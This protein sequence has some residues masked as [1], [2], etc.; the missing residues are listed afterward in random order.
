MHSTA[1]HSTAQHIQL[2]LER[3][4]YQNNAVDAVI[5]VFNGNT[6]NTF[7][8]ACIEGVRSNLCTLTSDEIAANIQKIARQNGID[9]DT[10][11]PTCDND[12][13]LEMET[14]TGKTLVYIKTIYK[15]HQTYGFTKF[16]ILVPSVAIRQGVLASFNA[17][18]EQLTVEHNGLT[19]KPFDYDSKQ[20][21]KLTSFIEDQHPQVMV[22]T[23]ASFNSDDKILNQT[24]RDNLIS[25]HNTFLDA[26]AQTRPIIIMD[27]PQVGM[28]TGNAQTQ[29]AK[30]NP[31]VK[32]R[33]SATHESV[34][35]LIYR[36]TPY[37]SYKQN[38]VK[39]I[40]VL[41]VTE[42]N[43]EATFN[44]TLDCA[45]NLK[46]EPKV[47]IKAWHISKSKGQTDN[48]ATAWLKKNDNLGVK[49][50]NPSYNDF[51]IERI[52]KSLKT[53]KWTVTFTNGKE[54]TESEQTQN[55]EN[56]WAMQIEWLIRRH[57]VK[58][59]KL[60]KL[61]IKCLSLIFIDKV[62]NYM[63]GE[64]EPVI[65]NLFAIK[66]AQIHQ[67]HYG[68]KVDATQIHAIQGYYFASKANGDMADNEGGVKEQSKI[69][70]LILEGREELLKLDNPVQ[71]IFSHTALGVGWDNPN[72]FNIATLKTTHSENRQRQEIGRGL[73]ICVNQHGQRVHD[74]FDVADD[75][76]INQL[77]VIPNQSYAEFVREYQNQ[78]KAAYGADAQTPDIEHSD[79]GVKPEKVK[80]KRNANAQISEAFERFW[81]AMAQKTDYTIAFDEN[82]LVKK[83]IERLNEIRI[84]AYAID[85]VSHDV[86]SIG[87]TELKSNY[88]GTD[89]TVQKAQFTPLD[90]LEEISENTGIDYRAL[91]QVF[92]KIT[93][94]TQLIKNPPKFIIEASHI[95]R[96][97]EMD[98]MLRGL[99]YA[100]NGETHPL[101]AHDFERSVHVDKIVNTPNKGVFDK[102]VVDSSIEREF[103]KNLD[104]D[105]SEVVCFIKLPDN[106]TIKIPQGNGIT[107]N[108]TPD[109]GIVMKRKNL[110]D[111]NEQELYFVIETKGTNDINDTAALTDIEKF[112][113]KCA[114]KHFASIGIDV[115]YEAPI[116][117]YDT[118]KCK[119]AVGAH[120]PLHEI[121]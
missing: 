9:D 28:G 115:R 112:K 113:I 66:Y 21:S 56:I 94:H 77:T 59:D 20:L 60:K 40:E 69:Y 102:I 64:H 75:A 89:S 120:L 45:D 85:V 88:A 11:Q 62:V 74:A 39:K 58:T 86:Q 13:S 8:N 36:L 38:L 98:E 16:I 91:L 18:K 76:R 118:F 114:M 82:A 26:L 33:Y 48:K 106:Y 107:G 5:H 99:T 83:S 30:L 92:S 57:F 81:Q 67:E 70:K 2:A 19:L 25:N 108:Y 84:S 41:T 73:R 100:L 80:F 10:A 71:F 35:N 4:D 3:L 34:K 61:G 23:L 79:Q 116:K 103:A 44:M 27:E 43:D 65:K 52:Q 6:K 78:I 121:A 72:V 90:I 15:L 1:Q 104:D 109:F 47:K 101:M 24:G 31:L 93:N 111:S 50:N 87:A 17:F 42:Q 97:V 55:N 37:D 119:T 51:T 117:D 14:G 54:L 95:L 110:K 49:T 63:G 32:I 29:I 22:M 105:K 53:G 12:L 68:E 7:D 96:Q 46:G